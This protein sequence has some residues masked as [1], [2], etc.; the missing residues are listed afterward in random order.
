[1]KTPFNLK[2]PVHLLAAG[3]GSGL[4]PKA[5]G[6]VGTL[7]AIPFFLLF[8]HFLNDQQYLIMLGLTFLLG[9]YLCGKTAKDIGVHDHGGIV[10]DEFVGLWITYA[11]LPN[12][13]WLWLLIGFA[14][15]RFFDIVKPFPIGLIDKRIKGGFGIMI[16]DVIAGLYALGLLQACIHG[17][18]LMR[19]YFL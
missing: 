10:F 5:P 1:M 15:F 3:F 6:T 19:H 13:H 18:L 7:A 14:C 8:Y 11:F 4:S 16:D 17:Y 2:H 12:T 9:I